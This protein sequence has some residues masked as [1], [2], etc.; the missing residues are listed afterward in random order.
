[1]QLPVV[2]GNGSPSFRLNS[3]GTQ[4]G[5]P[6]PLPAVGPAG[7]LCKVVCLTGT[8]DRTRHHQAELLVTSEQ[9]ALLRVLQVSREKTSTLEALR[10]GCAAKFGFDLSLDEVRDLAEG[11]SR[12]GL[13]SDGAAP[14]PDAPAQL[15][16]VRA[17]LLA[18]TRAMQAGLLRQ[19]L[20]RWREEI[21]FFRDRLAGV[22]V[23]RVDLDSLRELPTMK[24][25]DIRRELPRMLPARMNERFSADWD[26]SS[27]TTGD[28][29]QVAEIGKYWWH[30]FVTTTRW[31]RL[32]PAPIGVLGPPACT[33]TE[34]H[35][36][37]VSTLE[38]RWNADR[39]FLVLGSGVDPARF[40][41]ATLGRMLE[42]LRQLR[43][44]TLIADGAYLAGLA[45]HLRRTGE[46]LPDVDGMMLTFAV[47]S[48]IHKRLFRE[49]VT[50][51]IAEL[52]GTTESGNIA[53]ECPSGGLHH[54]SPSLYH[55]EVLDEEGRPSPP[56]EIGRVHLTSLQKQVLPLLRYDI[57]DYARAVADDACE[58]AG[59]KMGLIEGR[60]SDRIAT[61]DGA[62]L[63]P[64]QVDRAV[65]GLGEDVVWYTLVQEGPR[66][67]RFLFIPS[68][69]EG[70]GGVRALGDGLR[71]LL[72]ADADVSV[73]KTRAL[74]PSASGKFRLCW[75]RG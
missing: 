26:A 63:L 60:R 61:T 7:G 28:R 69:E 48:E 58:E 2:T 59:P 62:P 24:K 57:G 15:A 40:S 71:D 25:D 52:Y 5:W 51:R 19:A 33:G 34:C 10:D 45:L 38:E 68:E 67:Y 22:E 43:V 72:G 70:G 39:G 17:G 29:L 8:D 12:V 64:R 23:D 18:A 53:V 49:V 50:D 16:T 1:M 31:G 74:V 9:A 73:E 4:V 54:V 42:E 47:N 3:P 41:K 27:G 6:V 32:S 75:R 56:G 46:R 36:D 20:R 37:G 65:A 21:P 66:A 11:L 44:R 14:A 55:V 30:T 13:V 35:M